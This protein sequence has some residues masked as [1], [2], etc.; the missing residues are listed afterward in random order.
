MHLGKPVISILTT[1]AH[2]ERRNNAA[3]LNLL[4]LNSLCVHDF[5]G[6][7]FAVHSAETTKLLLVI[8]SETI[9]LLTNL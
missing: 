8:A 3:S 4:Q 2:W 5:F 1:S 9:F 6:S 7:T